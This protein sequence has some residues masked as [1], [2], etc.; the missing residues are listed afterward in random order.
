MN[1]PNLTRTGPP[2][3][4]ALAGGLILLIAGPALAQEVPRS[5]DVA[6]SVSGTSTLVGEVAPGTV[7]SEGGVISV[8]NNI[9]TTI[10]QSSDARVSGRATIVV[11]FDAYPDPAGQA[12]A[13]QVRYGSMR[14]E[15]PGGAWSGRFAGR[16]NAS[17]FLQTYWLEGEGGYAGLSYT[18]T[19]GGNG[20]TWQSN[21][22][23][24]PGSIPPL[25][26]G[27]AFPIEGPPADLPAA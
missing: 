16:L 2:G 19:A 15:N 26:P 22:L 6:V 10:E 4:L 18:V 11:N 5:S 1:T 8:R 13:T 12:G 7:T 17:G 14:L 21:G 3:L 20:Q 23:I 9:L 27:R 25:G 24:Y